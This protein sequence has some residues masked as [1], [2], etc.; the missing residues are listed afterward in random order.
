M[1]AQTPVA[2]VATVADG[3]PASIRPSDNS[4]SPVLPS[5]DGPGPVASVG[6][7]PR[8]LLT[9]EGTYPFAHGGV[10]TWCDI[11]VNGIDGVDWSVLPITAGGI[12]RPLLFELPANAT[13]VG[14]IDLWSERVT[15]RRT[16]RR[17]SLR[18]SVAAE[19]VR[20]LLHWDSDPKSV[21][22]ALVWCRCNPTRVRASMRHRD[23]WAAY[24]LALGEVLNADAAHGDR[25]A[26]VLDEQHVCDLFQMLC[27]VAQTAAAPTPE[28][29]NAPDLVLVTAAGWAGIPAAVHYALH[30]TPVVLSEHGVYVREAY[31]AAIRGGESTGERW[32]H[33]R[34]ARGLARLTYA[35]ATVVA[36]VTNANAAWE[37]ALGADP[38]R[39]RTIHN[40]V[41]VPSKVAP[42]PVEPIVVT[43]GR[44]DPLKDLKTLLRA[45]ASVVERIPA[46]RFDHYGPVP[47]GNDRY[48][49]ECLALHA[50][51]NL[52]DHFRFLGPIDDPDA[53][54]A[55][56]RVSVL[57]SISEGFPISVLEAMA[58]GRPVVATA[59]GGVPEA[60]SGCGFTVRPGD[61]EAL[62]SGVVGLLN[63]PVL[64]QALGARG[65]QRVI[66]DFGQEG[67]LLAYAA[68]IG[69]L[70]G[71]EPSIARLDAPGSDV[72]RASALGG[73]AYGAELDDAITVQFAGDLGATLPAE[74]E[75]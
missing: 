43:I 64:A 20:A 26:P 6:R 45:A 14:H 75:L 27:W 37:R 15:T 59:V 57:S 70:T 62:A 24:R 32:T 40:G 56:A 73:S 8:V 4:S 72:N 55:T 16:V 69:E 74:H 63:D 33:T 65:R 48:N 51:L 5:T 47:D 28:G 22:D 17:S 9:T 39:I 52:G 71:I 61:Y 23:A 34:L 1:V 58:A 68:L 46:A 41:L 42:F 38:D 10:S 36:P 35:V 7:R 44:I 13:M 49:E 66:H 60:V 67:C 3:P 29:A 54:L 21:L 18:T 30:A 53:A 2:T 12:R 19:F 31:L 11:V 50:D 25:V